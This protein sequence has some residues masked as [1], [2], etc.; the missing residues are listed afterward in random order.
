MLCERDA[1]KLELTAS[2]ALPRFEFVCH[3]LLIIT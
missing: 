1:V 3:C 2:K